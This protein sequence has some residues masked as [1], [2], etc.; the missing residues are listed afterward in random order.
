[1]TTIDVE[2]AIDHIADVVS[3]VRVH[4]L[5][6]MP[7]WERE[8]IRELESLECCHADIVRRLRYVH[9]GGKL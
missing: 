5:I 9:F 3:D 4:G 7:Q 8:L 1:M 2:R 6:A